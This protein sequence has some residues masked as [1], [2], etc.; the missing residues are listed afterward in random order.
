MNSNPEDGC[1]NCKF[2]CRS[3]CLEC[4][5][6]KRY[7]LT[8]LNSGYKIITTLPNSYKCSPVCGDGLKIKNLFETE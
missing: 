5:A 6:N 3:D 8:C 2:R 1:D 4:S 7:C